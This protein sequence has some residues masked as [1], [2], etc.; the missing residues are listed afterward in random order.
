MRILIV[1]CHEGLLSALEALLEDEKGLTVAGRSSEVETVLALVSQ[2]DP[3]LVL[4]DWDQ[5]F[6]EHPGLL[7]ALKKIRPKLGV[8]A[9]SVRPEAGSRALA[10]GADAFI[11]K[12][13]PPE[14]LVTCLHAFRNMV[15]GNRGDTIPLS[16]L[17]Q[18][19]AKSVMSGLS[20]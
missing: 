1:A 18:L 6:G 10:A 15:K 20:T 7:P 9:L 16:S 12:C 3:D 5:L 19:R 4:L 2:Q 8:V 13:D 14:R 11:C 17:G